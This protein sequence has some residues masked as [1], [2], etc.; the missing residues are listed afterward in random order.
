MKMSGGMN[1]MNLRFHNAQARHKTIPSLKINFNAISIRLG[2]AVKERRTLIVGK[3][4]RVTG[5][6]LPSLGHL[7][8]MAKVRAQ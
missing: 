7:T 8:A 5:K 6:T 1:K 2:Q 3:Y 4:I